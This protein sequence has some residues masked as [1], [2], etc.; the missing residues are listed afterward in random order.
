MSLWPQ[1]IFLFNTWTIQ[2][3][4]QRTLQFALHSI[5]F[6]ND[7]STKVLLLTSW[8]RLWFSHDAKEQYHRIVEDYIAYMMSWIWCLKGVAQAMSYLYNVVDYV[9]MEFARIT[10]DTVLISVKYAYLVSN[11]LYSLMVMVCCR[12]VTQLPFAR[13][14]WNC[15][16]TDSA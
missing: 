12:V 14:P 6:P 4:S 13:L 7:R 2:P 10:S 11:Y 1:T 5:R 16:Q 9:L 3:N 15:F 8:H